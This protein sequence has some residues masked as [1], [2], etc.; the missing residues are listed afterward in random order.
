M[1]DQVDAVCEGTEEPDV[2]VVAICFG[3]E[4]TV[5]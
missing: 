2:Q 1:P 4:G 3:F 5:F